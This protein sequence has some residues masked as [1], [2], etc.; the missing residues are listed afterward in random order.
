[1]EVAKLSLDLKE[2]FLQSKT[3]RGARLQTV[4]AECEKIANLLERKP[5]ALRLADEPQS[6]QVRIGILPEATCGSRRAGKQGGSL[7]K[8]NGV[9]A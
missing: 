3:Y 8:A 1:L 5:Q 7:V 2:F 6:F 9:R 4:T